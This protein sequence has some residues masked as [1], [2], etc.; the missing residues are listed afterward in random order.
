MMLKQARRK[1]IAVL[2]LLLWI[3]S[4]AVFAAQ[5]AFPT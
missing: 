2:F 4:G 5:V 1:T 3:S